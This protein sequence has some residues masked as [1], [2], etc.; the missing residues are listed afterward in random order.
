MMKEIVT[1]LNFDG[2]TREAMTFYSVCL[3]GKLDLIS[4][5]DHMAGG[6]PKEMEPAKD[7][8][9]HARLG[10]GSTTF[11]MASDTMP[12]IPL[13]AGNNFSISVHCESAEEIDRLFAAL[14]E[15]GT[16]RMPVQD[17]SWGARFGMLTDKFGIQW[18]FNFEYPKS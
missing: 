18:I 16:A 8:I 15:G 2:T 6:M 13:Q 17:A 5:G 9:M 7:R 3:G 14:G 12:G 10:K 4:F 1:Y 11:L